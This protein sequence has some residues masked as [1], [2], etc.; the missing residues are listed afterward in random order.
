[1]QKLH[2]SKDFPS[3]PVVKSS[4]S[5]AGDASSVPGRGERGEGKH[6]CKVTSTISNKHRK[7]FDMDSILPWTSHLPSFRH[8][9]PLQNKTIRVEQFPQIMEHLLRRLTR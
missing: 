3:S 7:E 1:M 4:P 6:I 2:S 8:Q 5:N 9:T